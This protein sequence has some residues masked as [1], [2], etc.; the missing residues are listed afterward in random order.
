MWGKAYA[1]VVND[2]GGVVSIPVKYTGGGFVYAK[3]KYPTM[4][5]VL[6]A[7]MNSDLR[8][9]HG[10]WVK[11]RCP[12]PGG[13]VFTAPVSKKEKGKTKK[14]T[15]VEPV[16]L[17]K[18]PG[19]LTL[20]G[21]PDHSNGGSGDPKPPGGRRPSL[22]PVASPDGYEY[23]QEA[24]DGNDY[25][26]D[27]EEEIGAP[28]DV[29]AGSTHGSIG[30][31]TWVAQPGRVLAR[32]MSEQPPEPPA[33]LRTMSEPADTHATTA[34]KDHTYEATSPF[35]KFPLSQW[36]PRYDRGTLPFLLFSGDSGDVV[37]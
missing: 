12:A 17:L 4:A 14:R 28:G 32:T 19:G 7:I 20:P 8:S 3:E 22:F 27:E 13:G 23:V 25:Y 35:A 33:L 24:D 10:G 5:F 31:N 26:Y 36:A 9:R 18:A 21:G 1:V 15:A 30:G 29:F 34:L 2:Q 11:L 16:G 6:H 37:F